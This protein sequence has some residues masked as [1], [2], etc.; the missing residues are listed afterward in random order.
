MIGSRGRRAAVRD[1]RGGRDD[2]DAPAETA[3]LRAVGPGA[4]GGAPAILRP[5]IA[6]GETMRHSDEP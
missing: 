1:E 5:D 6:R 2:G 4:P 3:P